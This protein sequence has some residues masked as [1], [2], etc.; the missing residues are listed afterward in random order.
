MNRIPNAVALHNTKAPSAKRVMPNPRH[1]AMHADNL[2][3]FA[4]IELESSHHLN[5]EIMALNAER[6]DDDADQ[7]VENYLWYAAKAVTKCHNPEY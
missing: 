7:E 6:D 4:N 5:P 3:E 2:N 1:D